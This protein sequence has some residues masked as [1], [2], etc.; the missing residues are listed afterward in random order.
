MTQATVFVGGRIFTGQRYCAA[1]LVEDGEVALAGSEE[2]VRRSAPTGAEVV[3]LE[4]HLA[5]PG[6]IDAHV[7]IA[8]VTRRREGL[9]V[10]HVGSVEGLA[11]AVQG[12]IATHPDGPVIGR[13]FDPERWPAG[14]WP[15]RAEL[16]RVTSDRPLILVHA[17]GHALIANS[18]ALGAAGIDRSTM[19][20]VGGRIGRGPD[21]TPDG[22]LFESARGL[23]EH[24]FAGAERVET[25]ALRTT[26]LATAALG[27]TTV[28][29]MSASPEEAVGLRELVETE[30]W[31][32]RIRVYLRGD[33]WREYFDDPGGPSGPS[34]RFEVVGVKAFT[35]GAFGPR[36]ALLSQPYADDPGNTGLAVGDDA[37]LAGLIDAATGAGLSPAL[38]AIGDRAVARALGLL[39]SV[40]P[41]NLR[42]VRIEHASLTPPEL[43]PF[44]AEVR[45]ALVVQPGFVW[46]D[47]WL[48][49][50]LGAERARWAYAFRTLLAQGHRLVG[51]SDAP[52]DPIDPWR[53]LRACIERS[54]AAGASA[55]PEPTEAV[56]AA[57]AL[58]MYTN[59]AGIALGEPLL[60]LLE[61]GGPADLVC[62]GAPSLEAAIHAGAPVVRS[63]WVAGERIEGPARA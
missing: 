48:A 49:A 13:G 8:E 60:G 9:D 27:I 37:E 12:W 20:P 23:L 30:A 47:H 22:R 53:G 39:R 56:D 63:T 6:L 2:E 29:A 10:S 58:R 41:R 55:N 3:P 5:I 36:T 7:H 51:S 54:D 42:Q 28:G 59:H 40:R 32:G 61:A 16:D 44:L 1:L 15:R 11:A 34:E 18:A 17:S 25:S 26:L 31:K 50:R 46:S 57:T 4:G 33:R 21:G 24:R 38:H 52:Y 35:D 62:L 14:D 19:D 45:P 43:L